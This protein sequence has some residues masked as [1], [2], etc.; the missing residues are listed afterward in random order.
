LIPESDLADWDAAI[1]E[2]H[3]TRRRNQKNS[4]HRRFQALTDEIK[5]LQVAVGYVI[6]R[7][8]PPKHAD[9]RFSDLI[10]LDHYI[11]FCLKRAGRTLRSLVL[12]FKE[13]RT[14]DAL[15][16]TRTLYELYL[17]VV[18]IKANPE[19][20]RNLVDAHMGVA[21]G[22]HHF[23]TN[24]HGRRVIIEDSTGR[25]FVPSFSRVK[26]SRA[27][28][29]TSDE[30]LFDSLYEHLSAFIHPSF[31]VMIQP[32]GEG[33]AGDEFSENEPH[34]AVFYSI[35]FM[36]MLLDEARTISTMEKKV[37]ADIRSIVARVRD[38]AIGVNQQFLK[39]APR[40]EMYKILGARL[41][42]LGR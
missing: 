34:E 18:Y 4:N 20:L 7:T 17:H 29:R 1:E 11:L 24:K 28:R 12:L 19:H 15:A 36:C 3:R 5:S 27:S 25:E 22:T 30:Q 38:K 33:R 8:I 14:F 10:S 39:V 26:M 23:G 40:E 9:T 31:F 6:D 41:R 42:E 35:L 13:H 2:Y 21:S 32:T 16:L 37:E